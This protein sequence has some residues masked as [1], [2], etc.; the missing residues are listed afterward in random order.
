MISRR[1]LATLRDFSPGR[2]AL[3]RIAIGA[4]VTNRFLPSGVALSVGNGPG[5]GYSHHEKQAKLISG[6]RI[7]G[8][9]AQRLSVAFLFT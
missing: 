9:G 4:N 5:Y 7:T 8:D 1:G 2:T 6:K 3:P